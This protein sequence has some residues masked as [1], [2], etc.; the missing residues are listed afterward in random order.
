MIKFEKVCEI[1]TDT[2]QDTQEILAVF[3]NTEYSA[4]KNGDWSVDGADIYIMRSLGDK[5]G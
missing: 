4:C 1:L 3:E 2:K 5:E